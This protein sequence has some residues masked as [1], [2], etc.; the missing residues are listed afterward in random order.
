[1]WL[2]KRGNNMLKAK[3]SNTKIVSS[4]IQET[5]RGVDKKHNNTKIDTS[6]IPELTDEDWKNSTTGSYY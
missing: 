2:S 3:Q 4:T 1:M 6:E 5:S